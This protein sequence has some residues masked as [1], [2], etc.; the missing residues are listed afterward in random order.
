MNDRLYKNY[1][2]SINFN[3]KNNSHTQTFLFLQEH[4]QNLGIQHPKVL[5]IGCSSGYF[6]EALR[7]HGAYVYAV[8]PFST[9]ARDF[10]RVDDFFYGTVEYFCKANTDALFQTFDAVI[11][12]DVLEHLVDPKAVL[13]SLG[14][15]LKNDGVVIASVPNITHI[16]IR[17]MLEDNLWDYQ[18]YGI[19][20]STHIRFFSWHSLRKMFIEAGFGMERRYNVLIPEFRVYPSSNSLLEFAAGTSLNPHDHTFQ[21]VVRAS[22]KALAQDAYS[23]S[24]PQNILVLSPNPGSSVTILRLLK[25]LA[26]YASKY[27]GKLMAIKSSE[28]S[29]EHL[30][31]ADVVIAH[32]EINILTSEMLRIARKMEIPTI[33]DTDDL[34]TSLPEWSSHK[35][36]PVDLVLIKNTI[37]TAD[38]VT[39]TTHNLKNELMKSADNVQIVPN[40]YLPTENISAPKAKHYSDACTLVIASSDTVLVDFLVP[41]VRMLCKII[42]SLKVVAIGNIAHKFDGIAKNTFT[43][44]VCSADMFSKI[45]NSIDNGIGLIPLDDSLFSSCKSPIKHYNYTVCGIVSVASCCH[46]YVD[47]IENE[48]NGILVQNNLESWCNA[49]ANLIQNHEKRQFLLANALKDWQKNAARDAATEAW[50]AAFANLPKK[51]SHCSVEP[52]NG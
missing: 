11:L 42:P 28:C 46:P 49:V 38:R 24:T 23:D 36:D 8:E 5:E 30:Q 33:Y 19:L 31:W 1:L 43:Y 41:V 29:M 15:F 2:G 34:L 10:S 45:I 27:S 12:G 52:Y 40:V 44:G 18:K 50:R 4:C 3:V 48:K 47:C 20:D 13:E 26:E 21:H 7:T 32:R 9:E 22:K 6:S 14:K 37:S 17:T 35:I 16:G 51:K 39:C 25:P